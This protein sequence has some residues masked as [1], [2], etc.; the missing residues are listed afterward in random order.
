M[1][2]IVTR[3]F[4]RKFHKAEVPHPSILKQINWTKL[5]ANCGLKGKWVQYFNEDEYKPKKKVPRRRCGK[6]FNLPR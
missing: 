5:K 4:Q 6:C 3:G 1:I 2:I